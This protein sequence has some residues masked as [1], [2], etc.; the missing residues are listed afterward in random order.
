MFY[1]LEREVCF[2]ISALSCTWKLEKKIL[3][4]LFSPEQNTGYFQLA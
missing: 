3:K 2:L 1:C 4:I